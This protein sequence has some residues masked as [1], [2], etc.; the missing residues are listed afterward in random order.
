MLFLRRLKKSRL[1]VTGN[2][3]I[4]AAASYVFLGPVSRTLDHH[5][6]NGVLKFRFLLQHSL[7]AEIYDYA[8]EA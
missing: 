3:P 7:P 2:Y 4:Q 1:D 8:K 5:E 6:E